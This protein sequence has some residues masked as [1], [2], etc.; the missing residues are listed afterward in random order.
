M[1]LALAQSA[2]QE[3]AASRGRLAH[4]WRAYQSL[5]AA[6]L[7]AAHTCTHA[8]P[9]APAPSSKPAAEDVAHPSPQTAGAAS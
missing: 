3:L 9:E 7:S 8:P 4:L 5:H 1:L 2:Q 6:S